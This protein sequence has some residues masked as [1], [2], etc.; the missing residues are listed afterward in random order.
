LSVKVNQELSLLGDFLFVI[1]TNAF[2]QRHCGN[3]NC[4]KPHLF[5]R[6][7]YLENV[8]H[9]WQ[10]V[11]LFYCEWLCALVV[12]GKEK[13]CFRSIYSGSILN[14]PG[15]Q[16][17]QHTKKPEKLDIWEALQFDTL[18]AIPIVAEFYILI[19]FYI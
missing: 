19:L 18:C 13:N 11:L 10:W 2:L 14:S 7:I 8:Y 6:L 15:H 17:H 16:L 1:W 9:Y 12:T 5:G 4:A 3:E